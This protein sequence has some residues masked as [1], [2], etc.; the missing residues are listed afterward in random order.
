MGMTA[1]W[2]FLDLIVPATIALYG[3]IGA[4]AW[5]GAT[6]SRED[7]G[8]YSRTSVRR[9]ITNGRPRSIEIPGEDATRMD[10]DQLAAKSL[11]LTPG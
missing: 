9:D 10:A 1:S 2:D 5:H 6:L 3:G 7:T 8:A 11:P 4:S